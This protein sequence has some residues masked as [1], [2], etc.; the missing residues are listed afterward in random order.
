MAW[1]CTSSSNSGLVD[2]LTNAQI[3]KSPQI[4]NAMRSTDRAFFSPRS[5]YQD[6]PQSIGHGATISAP[7][8]HAMALESLQQY[9]HPG[10]TVLDVGSG[11]GYLVAV[12]SKLVQ[13]NGVVCGIEH[14]QALHES[15][16]LNFIASDPDAQ[17]LLDSQQVRFECADGRQGWPGL[18]FDA[19]HVGA[20]A[21]IVPQSL[22]EQ[23]NSPGMIFIPVGTPG[24]QYI[25]E[26][27]KDSRGQVTH[28]KKY[29]VSYVPLTDVSHY[30]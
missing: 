28:S 1:R 26:I 15:A 22:I 30:A 4:I 17:R 27:S 20:A 13:P 3:L 12:M 11:S 21:H 29:G 7:H 25:Y 24:S 5:P 19:I 23:L 6:A 10:A 18:T 9:L 8:M 16:I 14:I 2:N